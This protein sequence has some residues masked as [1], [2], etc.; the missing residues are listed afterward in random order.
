MKEARAR[1][2]VD[3]TVSYESEE[4]PVR[5]SY[6]KG[7]KTYSEECPGD[8]AGSVGSRLLCCMSYTVL[9]VC[10]SVGVISYVYTH[11]NIHL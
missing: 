5:L 6:K 9:F 7:R 1:Q 10:W 2:R 3:I 4:Y 8:V 11:V